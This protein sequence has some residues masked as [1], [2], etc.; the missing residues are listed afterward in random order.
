MSKLKDY[1]DMIIPQDLAEDEFVRILAIRKIHES[2]KI[3]KPFYAR[4]YDEFAEI[5]KK[6]KHN[7]NLFINLATTDGKGGKLENLRKRKVLFLDF[8]KKDY[9][10]FKDI[11]DFT[12]HIKSKLPKLYNHAIVDSGGGYHIYIA[13][14]TSK[15]MKRVTHVNKEIAKI[16]GADLQAAISTQVARIPTSLNQKFDEPKAVLIVSNTYGTSRFIPYTLAEL[17][18]II[19]SSVK[20][21]NAKPQEQIRMEYNSNCYCVEKMLAEGCELHERNFALGRIIKFLQDFHGYNES[22]AFE[23]VRKWN[24]ICNPPKDENEIMAD[25]KNY[26]DSDYNLLGCAI[27]DENKQAILSRYCDKSKCKIINN[28]E[29]RF[30]V[31]GKKIK[32]NNRLLDN[33]NMQKLNGNHYL[34][35]TILLINEEGLSFEQLK[36]EITPKKG[37]KPCL[38][39]RTLKPVLAKLVNDK[40]ISCNNGFY[41]IIDM[42]NYGRGYTR[43]YYFAAVT[44][45][46]K[47]ITAQDYL[48]YIALVR[49]MQQQRSVTHNSLA[50]DL[51]MKISQVCRCISSL[52]DSKLLKIEK[53]VNTKQGLRANKYIL[54]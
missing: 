38:D 37:I 48:V 32:M 53:F 11:R 39:T 21:D 54:A 33:R 36:K 20:N 24:S 5:V 51:G 15:D 19:A 16:V 7:W 49:N 30:I 14:K 29:E 47:D 42:K 9:P 31:E 18:Y 43:I 45:I 1:Y 6:H 10:Q 12:K 35:I 40:I 17:E 3:E 8:D 25:F 23:I 41:K 50:N 46:N 13:I 27:Q 52:R 34:I 4:T 26:W 2:E 44:R 22:D 28:G